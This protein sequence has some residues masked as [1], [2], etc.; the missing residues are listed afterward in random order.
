MKNLFLIILV[1][2]CAVTLIFLRFTG[3]LQPDQM[4][5]LGKALLWLSSFLLAF[6]PLT[7][8][9]FKLLRHHWGYDASPLSIMVYGLAVILAGF[10]ATR[11]AHWVA[12]SD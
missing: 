10:I 2:G 8:S 7:I 4:S 5:A 1:L 9:I 3:R 6:A 12:D 11:I